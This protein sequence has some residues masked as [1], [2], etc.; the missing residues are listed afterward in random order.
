MPES[1]NKYS[2]ALEIF[3][4]QCD[5]KLLTH[6]NS[7]VHCGLCAESCIYY[8]AMKEPKFMPGKKVDIV[9]SIY[10]RYCTFTGK[11][12]PKLVGARDLDEPTINEMIDLL[13][14]SC[15]MCGRCTI[16]CSIGVDIA[17]VVRT[18]R[19]MLA[20]M[21][22]VP[23]S[24]QSTVNAAVTSGNNMAIPTDEFVDTIEWMEE[25]LRSEDGCSEACIPLN[26]PDKN[27]LYTLNPREPKFFPLSISAMA[28]IFH[29]A[30]ESW[31]LS[32][33]MYDVT[34]YAFFSGDPEEAQIIAR[35]LEGE[36]KNLNAKRCILGECGHGSRAFRWE[37][38]N[39]LHENFD[40][41]VITSV[42]LIYEYFKQGRIKLDK[43]KQTAMVTMHDPCNLVRNGG[44]IMQQRE[45]LRHCVTNFVETTPFGV[46]NYCCGGGGGQL[47][48]SEYNERRMKIGEI[49]ANQVKATGA[50][51]LVTPC[52]NCVDQLI[53]LN[54]A[55]KMGVQIKTL[56][57]IVADALV[58]E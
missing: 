7:C 3:T 17:Y 31:T 22:M 11:V 15:T 2:K 1:E 55:F 19:N 16:H 28:K 5:S 38:P 32:T 21:K 13:Y 8:I 23:A 50:T 4:S 57:E 34:N 49:K 33:A 48:M 36:M 43:S 14:G 26:Q 53:Q 46:D 24:L 9:S 58:M 44:I 37:A 12:F 40:F 45:I 47:A 18:G 10:R 6:L 39:Y 52:H 20:S 35:R 42:E 51:I 54:S 25:E 29:A 56:A 30:G 41:D 27:I